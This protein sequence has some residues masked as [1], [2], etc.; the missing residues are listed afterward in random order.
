[1]SRDI[2]SF[3][4]FNLNKLARANRGHR[5]INQDINGVLVHC[6]EVNDT[7]KGVVTTVGVKCKCG[8]TV[9]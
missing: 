5:I 4:P 2:N 8:V 1:M 9:H 7:V 6:P 3:D